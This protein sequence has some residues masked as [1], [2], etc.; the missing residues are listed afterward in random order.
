MPG[1]RPHRKGDLGPLPG[2]QLDP[3]EA[4]QFPHPRPRRPAEHPAHVELHRL[5][6]GPVA[7]V[8]HLHR[9]QER[10][11]GSVRRVRV[12]LRH[13]DARAGQ[14]GCPVLHRR[15]GQTV[16]ERVA[17]GRRLVDIAAVAVVLPV[18]RRAAGPTTGE[19]RRAAGPRVP[20]HRIARPPPRARPTGRG[21]RRSAP[22]RPGRRGP[23][24]HAVV[25]GP[26]PRRRGSLSRRP[27]RAEP[28]VLREARVRPGPH[29]P[30]RSGQGGECGSGG[31]AGTCSQETAPT[32]G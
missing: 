23:A 12:E 14:P 3:G 8:V 2:H 13:R 5:A 1:P 15:K 24:A 20:P 25:P 9:A 21:T 19:P 28:T 10:L 31:E 4:A 7:D 17:C 22:P 6:H 16:T 11:L 30:R 27:R 26:A 18:V 32:Q 29:L